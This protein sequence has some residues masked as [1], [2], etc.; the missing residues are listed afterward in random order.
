ML[1]PNGTQRRGKWTRFLLGAFA[2]A[3]LVGVLGL[4]W[5][6]PALFVEG[7]T[8]QADVIVVLGGD[9]GDRA[10]R[11]LE[12]YKSNSA[13]K[14]IISGR[15]DCY[16]IRDRLI[17]AGVNTNAI[18]V[19]ADSRNTRQNAEFSVRLMHE[20]GM[21]RAIVVTSWYHSRRALACFRNFGGNIEFSSFPAYNGMN[22]DHK[23][24]HSE[25][26]NVVREYIGIAW[27]L[28]RYG[29]IPISPLQHTK[30]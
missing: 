18:F 4:L 10:F 1:K 27:Y 26:S 15:G 2:L 28:V 22:M 5:A 12:L 3:L 13:P 7:G 30:T 20:Q 6:K 23:P 14:I 21:R 19:E 29:I 24:A 11:A 25:V 8:K 16:F 9:A 17:L